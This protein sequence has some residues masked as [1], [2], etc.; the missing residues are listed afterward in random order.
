MQLINQNTITID[1][2]SRVNYSIQIKENIKALILN[3]TFYYNSILPTVKSL[4]KHLKI[5]EKLVSTAYNLL[6]NENYIKKENHNYLVSY[7]EL[8]NYFFERN[9]SI[10]DAIIELGLEPSI[11]CLEKKVVVLEDEEAISMGF[12]P[13][14]KKDYLYINRIY[15]GSNRPIIILENYLPLHIFKDLDKKFIGTEPLNN[16]IGEH[17]GFKAHISKRTTK[18][19]NLTKENAILLNE[20][21]NAASLQSTNYVFDKQGRM[22]DYG[23]SHSISSYYF[24]ALTKFE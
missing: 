12:E 1:R 18:I 10:Y 21:V 6:A 7:I 13:N 8:T 20:S 2:R 16:Y 14:E 11:K 9:T 22:I 4:S 24:Q 23:Q 19:V 17:Y 15:F 5:S 3:Q